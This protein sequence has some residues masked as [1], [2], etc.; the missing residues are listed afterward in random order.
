M[1]DSVQNMKYVR[2]SQLLLILGI[3]KLYKTMLDIQ[4][5]TEF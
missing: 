2:D 4:L 3:F 5:L 1:N